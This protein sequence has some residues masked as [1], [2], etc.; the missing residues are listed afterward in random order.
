MDA[1]HRQG[2]MPREQSGQATLI[3]RAV[4]TRIVAPSAILRRSDQ[5]QLRRS[6]SAP[7][8]GFTLIEVMIVVAVIALLATIAVPS[9]RQYF[10]RS[11]RSAAQSAMMDIANRQQEFLLAN[12]AY[13][14]RAALEASG[15]APPAEVRANYSWSID[16]PADVRPRFVITFTPLAGGGQAS[17]V[18]LTLN[19]QGVRTPAEKWRR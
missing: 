8:R 9:Y 7:A 15:Y 2:N 1:R 4:V 16:L 17:D 5:S 11:N 6:P 19:D 10:I 13:A 18:T 14:D 3:E 12:R